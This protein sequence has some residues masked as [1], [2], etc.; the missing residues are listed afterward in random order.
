[1]TALANSNATCNQIISWLTNREQPKEFSFPFHSWFV[2]VPVT[3]S[4]SHTPLGH[5]SNL[6]ECIIGQE[7]SN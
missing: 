5:L 7:P 4:C 2:L 1:V 3:V 6:W